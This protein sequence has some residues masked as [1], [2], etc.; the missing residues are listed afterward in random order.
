MAGGARVI[1]A[2]ASTSGADLLRRRCACVA[3][4]VGLLVLMLA[5]PTGF[6]LAAEGGRRTLSAA[7]LDAVF[8][9]A[10]AAGPFEGQPPAAAVRGA[11]G[12]LTGYVVSTF[13][14][15]GSTG[16]SGK[17]LDVLVGVD[18]AGVITGALLVRQTEPILVI[19]ITEDDLRRYVAGFAG[20]NVTLRGT[21]AT[22]AAPDQAY[23][24]VI[25]G[26]SVS[27]AVIRDAVIRAVTAVAGSRGVLGRASA[28][29][30]VD[31]AGFVPATWAE[32]TADG[33]I[34][35]RRFTQAEGTK[36]LLEL[37]VAL[38][39]PARIGENLL[40]K[41]AYDRLAAMLG[42]ADQAIMIA[43]A[44]LVSVK[45]TA[46]VRSGHFERLQLVQGAR[47]FGLTTAG[48]VNVEALRT[49][50]GPE[51]REIGVFVIPA[52]A[53]FDA[54][55]PWR[56]DVLVPDGG[57]SAE[58]ILS[59][60]YALPARYVLSPQPADA[61]VAEQPSVADAPPLWQETW[62]SRWSAIAAVSVML[63]VLSVVLVFQEAVVRRPVFYRRLRLAYLA[64]TLLW[65]GWWAGGQLSVVNVLTFVHSLMT[66]FQWEFFLLDP[67]IFILWGYVAAALLFLGRGVYCGWLCPFGALQELLAE[68]A[69]LVRLP[70]LVVPF[71]LHERLW[72]L[73]YIIFLGL[74][75]V[76]LGSTRL[77]FVG[78]EIEPFK[79][80]MSMTFLRE[81]PFVVYAIALLLAGLFIERFFCRYLCPLGAALAIPAR[82]R[83]FEWLKRRPQ[84]GRECGICFQ[85]CQVQAIHPEGQIN[86]NECI[87]CLN[88]QRVYADDA[89]CP[90]L[91]ARRK[92]RERR[93][94]LAT[95]AGVKRGEV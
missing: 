95:G 85:R 22:G 39:T 38:A 79:T 16:Y 84:C 75:A 43:A 46:F 47:T 78:A 63:I 29:A 5:V 93:E 57:A 73:K 3:L 41:L 70:Q 14:T 17:P 8:P 76:S 56:L 86:P 87:H 20:I 59:I 45:G 74:F 18:G 89:L 58:A 2:M 64:V 48:Y 24:A 69:R 68:T 23:P 62:R 10:A 61:P 53:G 50:G 26:A 77:A 55:A 81:W 60:D 42:A 71:A 44:G 28:A 88:C 32:L 1:E 49:A 51:F 72:P 6:A 11:D 52:D 25:S 9:G 40:G 67:V 21:L 31:I 65:L 66:G 35:C 33:S 36:L 37:C 19:G 27:S 90:P 15:L 82:M 94:A 13:D 30:R 54:G 7:E 80:V 92:R 83:M 4:A 12:R 34:G 91:A